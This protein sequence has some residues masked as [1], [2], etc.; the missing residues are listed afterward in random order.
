MGSLLAFC[1][2][3]SW[4]SR[5]V[6]A[7]LTHSALREMRLASDEHWLENHPIDYA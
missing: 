3:L 1:A 6:A 2:V 7:S 5:K 4:K